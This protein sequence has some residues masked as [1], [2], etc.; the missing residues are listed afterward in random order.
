[1]LFFL[2]IGAIVLIGMNIYDCINNGAPFQLENV[3]I[4]LLL[5]NF[6]KVESDLEAIKKNLGMKAKKVD[7]SNDI[8]KEYP[9]DDITN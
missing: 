2:V 5:F 7:N 4:L 8:M 3:I 9:S 6:I 1:M